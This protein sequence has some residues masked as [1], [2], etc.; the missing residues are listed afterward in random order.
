MRGVSCHPP[1]RRESLALRPLCRQRRESRLWLAVL[2]TPSARPGLIKNYDLLIRIIHVLG[3]IKHA[4]KQHDGLAVAIV[5]VAFLGLRGW[6]CVRYCDGVGNSAI[7]IT[8]QGRHT[9][10]RDVECKNETH[11]PLLRMNSTWRT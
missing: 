9:Q 3:H 2:G 8:G 11:Y 1:A 5:G 10:Q 6:W 7:A 4:S